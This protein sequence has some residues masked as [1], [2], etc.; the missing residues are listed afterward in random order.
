MG[1]QNRE[2]RS[3]KSEFRHTSAANNK[4]L[5]GKIKPLKAAKKDKKEYDEE[6]QAFLDKKRAGRFH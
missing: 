1:G 2:G 3:P 5:G 6:D 4:A